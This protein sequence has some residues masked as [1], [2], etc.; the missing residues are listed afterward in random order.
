MTDKGMFRRIAMKS[1]RT[2]LSTT[3]APETYSYLAALVESGKARN[4]AEAVDEA[5]DQMRRSENRRRLAR[6]TAEY[7]GSL[8]PEEESEESALA[9]SMDQAAERIDFDREP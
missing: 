3:V 2:K 5:V 1:A 9:K 4:L 7:Y 8:S 6:A